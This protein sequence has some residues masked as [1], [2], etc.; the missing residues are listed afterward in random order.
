MNASSSNGASFSRCF[1]FLYLEEN[2]TFQFS[3]FFDLLRN[4]LEKKDRIV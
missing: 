4:K 3:R 2:K 1:V